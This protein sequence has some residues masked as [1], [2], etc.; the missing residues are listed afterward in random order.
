MQ[1][2]EM[3]NILNQI[4]DAYQDAIQDASFMWKSDYCCSQEAENAR[5]IE[6]KENLDYFKSLLQKIDKNFIPKI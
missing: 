3:N 1:N 5:N 2:D 4:Y 6:D